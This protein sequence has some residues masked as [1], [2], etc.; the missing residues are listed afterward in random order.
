M[1]NGAR[2]FFSFVGG[3]LAALVVMFGVLI[4]FTLLTGRP[5]HPGYAAI[6]LLWWIV[7]GACIWQNAE[8]IEKWL[9]ATRRDEPPS[10]T[11]D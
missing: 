4:T 7:V 9:N 2:L 1:S 3:G 8:S 10:P 5:P 11:R 6:I